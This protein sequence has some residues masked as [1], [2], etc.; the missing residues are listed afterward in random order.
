MNIE[1]F[2]SERAHYNLQEA[3]KYRKTLEWVKDALEMNITT[4]KKV[5]EEIKKAL[6]SQ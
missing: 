6:I 1:Q 5:I 4:K 2:E 3:L